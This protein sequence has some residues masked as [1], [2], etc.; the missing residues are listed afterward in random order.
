MNAHDISRWSAQF[1]QLLQDGKQ[2]TIK[3]FLDDSDIPEAPELLEAL[4]R[5]Q[6]EFSRERFAQPDPADA[7]DADLPTQAMRLESTH[8]SVG[9][10]KLLQK[11]GEGGMG[12]VFLAE[13][14]QPVR[15]RVALKII[16]PG[17][18]SQQVIARFEAERQALA[19]MDHPHISRVLDAGMTE[20]GR[21]YFVM[22]LVRGDPITK[23][24]DDKRLTPRER[25][26]LF[27]PICQA[28]QHAHQKGIIHRDIKPSNVLVVE[29]DDRPVAKVIDFGLAKAVS[30][31]LTD[32][33]IVT[34]IGQ[35]VGTIDYMS[36]EQASM[37]QYDVDTRTDIYSLGVMLYELLTG[38]TP[39]DK[40]RLHQAALDELVRIIRLEEPPRPSTRLSSHDSLPTIAANRRTEPKKLSL[41]VRGELDWIVMKSMEKER[42]R[43]YET[44]NG[45][46]RDIQRYLNG[47]A[48]DACPPSATYR[49]RKLLHRHRAAVVTGA[50]VL[51]LCLLGTLISTSQAVRASRAEK[52]ASDRHVALQDEQRKTQDALNAAIL[53]KSAETA[54]R[55]E[56]DTR[57]YNSLISEAATR[58]LTQQEGWR[59]AAIDNIVQANQ[60]DTVDRDLATLR[61]EAATCLAE[62]DVQRIAQLPNTG[63]RIWSMA[64][65]P[66]GTLL[67]AAGYN[68]KLALWRRKGQEYTLDRVVEEPGSD[69]KKMYS[70]DAPIPCVRFHPGGG[71]LAFSSWDRRVRF[72]AL[73]DGVTPPPDIPSEVQP[74]QI[75]F[76]PDENRIITSWANGQ[77]KVFELATGHELQTF[78]LPMTINSIEFFPIAISPDGQSLAMS[79][80]DNV[81]KLRKLTG[82]A[83]DAETVLGKH[84]D[85]VRGLRFTSDG[86]YCLSAS[87]DRTAKVWNVLATSDPITLLGHTSRV[88]SCEISPDGQWIATTSDDES[89]RVWNARTGESLMTMHLEGGSC[90]A[91]AFSPDGQH[92]AVF[93][94]AVHI[95]KLPDTR[96][97]RSLV[98]HSYAVRGLGFPSGP[99][100]LVS[101][102]SDKRIIVWNCETGKIRRS[103]AGHSG[104]SLMDLKCSPDGKWLVAVNRSF[105]NFKSDDHAVRVFG[106]PSGKV[107]HTLEGHTG[108]IAALDFDPTSRRLVTCDGAGLVLQWDLG[109]GKETQR[110]SSPV[111]SLVDIHY[112]GDGKRLLIVTT[113]K[114]VLCESTTGEQVQSY[115]GAAEIMSSTILPDRSRL[116]AGNRDGNVLE[117]RLPDLEEQTLIP[118]A[119]SGGVAALGISANGQLLATCGDDNSVTLWQTNGRKRL[120]TL[121]PMNGR[122][123]RLIF[124]ATNTYLA[125]GGI[126]E[127]VT[128]WNL[129]LLNSALQE[130]K[131]EW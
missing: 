3:S 94:N 44:A 113:G 102:S 35:V 119:Q 42:S 54:A 40:K 15:R 108:D 21:P 73:R 87:M 4:A 20:T 109:V 129:S 69:P 79:G 112:V 29:I 95:F 56:A 83:A 41:L 48:V 45:L 51:V 25:L 6:R 101:C 50:V 63:H 115:S 105:F 89:T 71:Y 33:T 122:I 66:D 53:A 62:F 58:R 9:P 91:M 18:D 111:E 61:G 117:I 78:E 13:Q 59:A 81:I 46:A 128:L 116:I 64:Y 11:L 27:V 121:P 126:D 32:Q 88:N 52:L 2:V 76:T 22:E 30:Q 114:C 36:P 110:W 86:R 85:G 127:H 120:L 38:D 130:S 70:A 57:L 47:E 74:R 75:S 55:A 124:D 107:Q 16:K 80:A 19:L 39:F 90:Q 8:V 7:V 43:R 1:R 118:Q 49:M 23:Y 34:Q 17:M 67:A 68:G 97:R 93:A 24:C 77:V 72:I 82:E 5:I 92:L 28:V 99:D 10:Y 31:Q 12:T 104:K 60:I 96:L 103:F 84:R 98:G 123:T 106:L 125:I 65:S 37:N 131:L 100:T 26:E 14:A